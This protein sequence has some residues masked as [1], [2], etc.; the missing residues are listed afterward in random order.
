VYNVTTLDDVVNS[1]NLSLRPTIQNSLDKRVVTVA[2]SHDISDQITAKADFLYS[3]TDTAYELNPQP[4]SISNKTLLAEGISPIS[5]TNLTIKNRFTSG[6]DRIYNN[7][8]NFYRATAELDGKVND[9]FN[10]RVYANYNISYQTAI[11]YNQILNSALLAGIKS[12]L[13]DMFATSQDSAKMA[14]AGVYGTSIANYT[15]ELYTYDAIINGKVW[16]LPSGP[17]QYAAGAEY[18]NESLSATADYNSTIP[19][20]GTTSLWNNGVSIS[21]FQSQRNTKSEFV[22]LKVPLFSPQNGIPGL[23]LLSVDGAYR[24][25]AYGD[26]NKSTVPKVS[27]RYLPFNDELALRATYAKSFEEP[28]LYDLYGPSNAGFTNSPSGLTAYNSAGVAVGAYP[29]VQG[30]EASGS[31]PALTPAKA[32]SWTLGAIYSPHFAKGLEISVDYFKIDQSDLITNPAS[33][34][35][36]MQSVEEYGPAS[37]YAK[38]V[39]LGGFAGQGGTY[40]TAP[41]QLSP[42]PDNVYV[43]ESLVNISSLQTRGWDVNVKYVL[44]WESFGRFTVNTEWAIMKKFFLKSG[45]DDPGTD[46]VGLD[47]EGTLPASRS[48]STIDWDYRAYGATLGYTHINHVS[49]LYGDYINPYNTFDLQFRMDLGKVSSSLRGA[50]FDVGVNN[51]TNQGPS[52]DRDNYSSPPFD[53]STY[54]YFGRTYY[55]DLKYKF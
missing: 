31:N 46:Y 34:L 10:W 2:A 36:M 28:T 8:S 50:S 5:D 21:P 51:L 45:P 55:V 17:I 41:G 39:T 48:Y 24:H 14:E 26:G 18:R 16:D 32:K 38:Y 43:L 12:G 7:Q 1:F 33:D 35:T 53:A 9:Y 6:P 42:A 44:P 49:N 11:G 25:E 29:A 23:H 19:V 52:L 4:V 37:P 13:I 22:E 47:E 20:G 27:L 40:V 30:Q 15:S 54:S 3:Y